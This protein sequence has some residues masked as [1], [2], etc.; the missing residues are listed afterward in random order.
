MPGDINCIFTKGLIPFVEKEAGP[1]GVAALCRTAGR[2]REYLMADHNWLPVS[3]ASEMVRVAMELTG[4]TDVERW[5]RRFADDFMDW[6]PSREYRHYL[7]TYS[8]GMGNPREL[9]SRHATIQGS[10]ARFFR[11]SDTR[12][13]R[14]RMT[15]RRTPVDGHA[16]PRWYC[17]WE[18]VQLER[19]PTNWDLPR[20]AVTERQC[21]AR[22]ADTCLVEVAW[23]NPP[24]GRRFW[25]PTAAGMAG[26]AA[27]SLGLAAT[28]AMSWALEGLI[29][30]L[31]VLLGG[32]V[33]HGLVQRARWQHTKRML[34]LQSE[35]ILYSNNELEKKFR[36]LETTIEQLSLLS[37]LSAAVNA[38]LD[39]E[40]IY[41]QALERLVN[42]MGY[43]NAYLFLVDH[44]RQVVRGHRMAGREAAPIRFT[45]V[46]FRL[47]DVHCGA[48]RVA[49]SGLPLVIDDV[50]TLAQP[51]D[52][53]TARAL[54]VRSAVMMPLR[55]KDVVFGVLD[56]TSTEPG[57]VGEADR[58]LLSAVANHVALAL[59]R[60]ESFQTIEE[61]SRSLEDKVRVRTE[62]LRTA[63]EELQA[64][65]R[66]LQATQM[67][68][69]QREKMAS[70]GQLVAGVAHELNNPIGFV[71]S[72]VTTL[73][74]FVRRLRA[75]L[76]AYRAAPLAE[77]DRVRL[78]AEWDS[79]K[80]DYAL[81][82]LD[83]MIQGIREGAE[84]AR[85]IV[86]DL[87]VFARTQDDV[88]QSVDIHEEIESSLTLLNHLLKDRVEVHR[89]Y[90][91]LPAVECIRSQMDQVFLNLLANA[92]Q[93]IPGPGAITIETR[94]DGPAAVIAI[95][96]T[97][98]GIPPEIMGRLFDPFFTTKP[99]GEGTG[100][101]LSIS[102]EIVKK[103]GGEIRAESPADG[104]A[105]FTVRIP[106]ARA[107]PA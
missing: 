14:N 43:Q 2:S 79:R 83:S 102:Y 40:K 30:S 29:A 60:A 98:P 19:Y 46:E 58:E 53:P 49:S 48:S 51:V 105:I 55:V 20:A 17:A 66:E 62:Q 47:D 11:I 7:G 95:A 37:E 44:A 33:G 85:K 99:V 57:R 64:A 90:G 52:L 104:G 103:H 3:V 97:G 34:D 18:T 1:E 13:R 107:K 75:M 23:K 38:T 56:V 32:A 96:D 89:K 106:L 21:A 31:P 35:E 76:E 45:D 61:L 81:K 80:V 26:S 100:L 71:Y 12:L 24:L 84:R 27:L 8:M 15:F 22:G 59:D 94:R 78:Q 73:E 6:K 77:G 92:A 16:M 5:A 42:Q 10:T 86:R 54:G 74:D 69:I 87:R 91:D 63:H 36:D 67:Q 4:D 9:Y 28:Q 72:N 82:Y 68:L 65:Y 101:G 41:E 88:W 25:G 93:A 50:E 39:V 70:V